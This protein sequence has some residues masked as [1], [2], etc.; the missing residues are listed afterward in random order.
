MIFRVV[1]LIHPGQKC[2]LCMWQE[3]SLSRR[4]VF[5]IGLFVHF[6][7]ILYSLYNTEYRT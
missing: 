7:A 1:S 4:L 3:H 5:K 6:A 2:A